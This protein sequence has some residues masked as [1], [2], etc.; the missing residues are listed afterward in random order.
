MET[1]AEA[2]TATDVLKNAIDSFD[3]ALDP[4]GRDIRL[5]QRKLAAPERLSDACDDIDLCVAELVQARSGR[6]LDDA[7]FDDAV[8]RLRK[9]LQ[10]LAKEAVRTFP[11]QGDGIAWLIQAVKETA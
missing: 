3:R 4:A 10:K 2:R 1:S 9:S 11:E 8:L 5:Q 6:A 7:A